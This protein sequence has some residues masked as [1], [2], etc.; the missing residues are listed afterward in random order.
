ML[1]LSGEAT[2]TNC[3]VFGLMDPRST[4][5]EASTLT[6]TP[7][8][9]FY[10]LYCITFI[11]Q[12]S[13]LV[14]LGTGYVHISPQSEY[15]IVHSQYRQTMPI[16]ILYSIGDQFIYWIKII[17]SWGT[18]ALMVLNGKKD[19]SYHSLVTQST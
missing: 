1:V 5:F 3:I 19:K 9:L 17:T 6:I 2:N 7:R 13:R 16:D 15:T 14:Y 18:V 10:L 8:M 12:G 4:A 11:I